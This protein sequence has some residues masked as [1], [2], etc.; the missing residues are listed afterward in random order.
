LGAAGGDVTTW[1]VGAQLGFGAFTVGGSYAEN[2]NNRAG[3]TSSTGWSLGASYDLAGPW[4]FSLET[5]QGEYIS[6]GTGGADESY[7]AYQLAASRDL[8]PGVDWDIYYIY[9]EAE[10]DGDSANDLEGN[11]IG[12]A[13]N[14]S[15]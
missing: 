14:L 2:N 1:A 13:I 3:L 10:D 11:I 5:Y 4:A 7:S 12:T 8:G 15:F 9:A 6:S